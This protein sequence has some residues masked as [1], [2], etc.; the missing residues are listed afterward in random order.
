MKFPFYTN[1]NENSGTS[2]CRDIRKHKARALY[3]PL[4]VIQ[5]FQKSQSEEG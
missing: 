1:L 2:N 5:S 3:V 4:P